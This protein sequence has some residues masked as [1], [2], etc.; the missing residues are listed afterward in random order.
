MYAGSDVIIFP[1]LRMV[2][3]SENPFE[4]ML[5]IIIVQSLNNN[6]YI[7]FLR[8]NVASL[9][10]PL[11]HTR[12]SLYFKFRHFFLRIKDERGG[13]EPPLIWV[14]SSIDFCWPDFYQWN[15]LNPVPKHVHHTSLMTRGKF[16][17]CVGNIMRLYEH[18]TNETLDTQDVKAPLLD[19]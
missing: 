2:H 11:V 1:H 9:K 15:P 17:K 14:Y 4:Q 12:Y 6:Y 19:R 7:K 3:Y 18:S 16:E 13:R 5:T 10:F 8:K